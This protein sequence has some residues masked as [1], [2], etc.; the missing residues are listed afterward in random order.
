MPQLKPASDK[1]NFLFKKRYTMFIKKKKNCHEESGKVSD[2]PGKDICKTCIWQRTPVNWFKK[3][4]KIWINFKRA[5]RQKTCT[6]IHK[7]RY[8]NGQ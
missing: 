2:R 7:R 3:K 8:P 6:D 5:E 4:K 1:L